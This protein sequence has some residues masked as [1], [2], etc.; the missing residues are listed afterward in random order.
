VVRRQRSWAKRRPWLEGLAR[1]FEAD[2]A[3][4]PQA[5]YWALYDD[6]A[7]VGMHWRTAWRVSVRRTRLA[8]LLLDGQQQQRAAKQLGVSTRTAEYDAAAVR[9]A[10]PTASR[11]RLA[12]LPPVPLTPEDASD[13]ARR[14]RRRRDAR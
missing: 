2:P 6:A 5:L 9:R 11:S 3:G 4:A 7:K 10:A 14:R 1:A 12:T 13:D 8:V